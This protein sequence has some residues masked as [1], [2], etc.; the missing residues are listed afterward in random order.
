MQRDSRVAVQSPFACACL[1]GIA[2]ELRWEQRFVAGRRHCTAI[3]R[4]DM[5]QASDSPA[6]SLSL[7]L[8]HTTNCVPILFFVFSPNQ[9]RGTK[10]IKVTLRHQPRNMH[11]PDIQAIQFP[12]F[13]FSP[14]GPS[15]P[16]ICHLPNHRDRVLR[17]CM[18]IQP[19]SHAACRTKPVGS[20]A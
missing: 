17:V 10:K 16:S 2:K 7:S 11:S 20:L 14:P 8:S 3:G 12:A 9:A 18:Y 4:E 13:L 5:T 1:P 15:Y 6:L 19:F